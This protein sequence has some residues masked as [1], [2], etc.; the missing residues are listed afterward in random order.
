MNIE[1]VT[2]GQAVVL[3]DGRTA[4]VKDNKASSPEGKH[5]VELPDGQEL[6]LDAGT[7][8]TLVR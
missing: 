5:V 8:V 7:E 2:G 4:T 6:Q 1:Q 3:P